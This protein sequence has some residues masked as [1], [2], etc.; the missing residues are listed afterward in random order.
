MAKQWACSNFSS[1]FFLFFLVDFSSSQSVAGFFS[2]VFFSSGLEERANSGRAQLSL[3]NLFP[4]SWL[5]L[6]A[7]LV[8]SSVLF[9]VMVFC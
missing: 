2:C 1:D 5:M 6:T 3:S 9:G 4:F 8:G 7:V